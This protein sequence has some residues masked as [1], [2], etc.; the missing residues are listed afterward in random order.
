[1]SFGAKSSLFVNLQQAPSLVGVQIR[2]VWG[3]MSII[4]YM[5]S[6]IPHFQEMLS[7]LI[8]QI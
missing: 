6:V 5:Y 8:A 2:L 7:Q 4:H 1:M 3:V